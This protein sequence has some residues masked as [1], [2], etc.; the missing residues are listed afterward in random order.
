MYVSQFFSSTE[1]R[2]KI[3]PKQKNKEIAAYASY[4]KNTEAKI[5][6]KQQNQLELGTS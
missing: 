2:Q 3:K 5:K 4:F 6:N 1:E